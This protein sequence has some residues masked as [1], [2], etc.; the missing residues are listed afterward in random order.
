MYTGGAFTEIASGS[1]LEKLPHEAS[2]RSFLER[3]L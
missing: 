2:L 3:L 1:F